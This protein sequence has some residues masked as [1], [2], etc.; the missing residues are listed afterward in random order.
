MGV[1]GQLFVALFLLQ[2]DDS[3]DQGLKALDANQPAAAE[4]FFRKAV[5]ADPSDYF[6]HFNLALALS[7]QRKDA[8]AIPE[9]RKTLEL[10]PGLYEANLNLGTL[11]LRNKESA[12]AAEPLHDAV[13]AKPTEARPQI[14]YAQ[15]LLDSGEAAEA[16]THFRAAAAIDAK[17]AAAQLGLGRA[18]MKQGKLAEAV[19]PFQQAA[20]DPA[21]KETPLELARAFEESH[22]VPEAVAIYKQ[23]PNN[24]T[25][26]AH[27]AG[28]L[29]DNHQAAEALPALEAAVIHDP[30]IHN[31]LALAD[32]YRDTKQPEKAIAQLQLALRTDAKS[33]ELRMNLGRLLRD[34]HRLVPAAEQFAEA[35]TIRPDSVEALHE[36]ASAL[37]INESYAEGL[38]ALDKVRALG[39]ETPGDMFYRGLSFDRLKQPRPALEAYQRFLAASQGK[40][41]DQEFQ[42]RQ[43]VRMIER[44]LQKRR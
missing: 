37:L 38:A 28:L 24:A 2:S 42:A 21:Y 44:E 14:L 25:V 29:L 22:Q 8:E 26:T 3:I 1:P 41:P 12:D 33:Y 13:E 31:R 4:G 36:L 27:A 7:Q 5:A 10:K 15:A 23:F 35:S 39:K 18:L 43:R 32:A 16:E 19:A 9:L 34:Q 17:S 40:L 20:Q 11:L 6:A 30:S